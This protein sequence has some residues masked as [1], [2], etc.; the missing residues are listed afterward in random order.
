MP[1]GKRWTLVNA[2]TETPESWCYD[3]EARN[4]ERYGRLY[5]WAAARKVCASM[6]ES[7]RLPGMQEWRD[8]ARVYGGLFGDGPGNGKD[9][10]GELLVNGRSGL[11]MLLGGGR[12]GEG[13]ARLEAH[14]FYW[15]ATEESPTTVRYL[16]FGKGSRTVYDQDG[17]AK[18]EAFSVR[19]VAGPASL[20]GA[21][22]THDAHEDRMNDHPVSASS[23]ADREFVHSR[24]IDATPERVFAA[25]STAS[26][27]AKWWGPK[28]FSS[29]FRT[30]EFHPGGRWVFELHAP[31]GAN[32][33]NENVFV[34]IVPARRVVIEHIS[35]THH[36]LL[37]ITLDPVEGGTRVGWRQVFDTA[38]HRNQIAH[39][40]LDANEQNLDR[41]AAEAKA[42]PLGN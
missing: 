42:A 21:G 2:S 30:F 34:E 5:T 22:K 28:G 38:E 10:F 26:R 39:V 9:A 8:L 37:T 1:D 40:V 24:V 29:T 6:G 35:E 25:L 32:Y 15:S 36:F 11:D 27:L 7:W 18:T 23:T 4:C 41:W 14:G 3:D 16:N 31:D 12:D 20:R 19:C 17:G 13:Y 33:P